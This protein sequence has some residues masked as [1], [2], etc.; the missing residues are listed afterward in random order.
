MNQQRSVAVRA[1]VAFVGLTPVDGGFAAG[2]PQWAD[3]VHA[4]TVLVFVRQKGE[5]ELF[6]WENRCFPRYLDNPR[7]LRS[8]GDGVGLQRHAVLLNGHAWA[9]RQGFRSAL[10]STA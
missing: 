9:C 8:D 7:P 1:P 4:E 5:R 3:A 2:R 6:P 10:A